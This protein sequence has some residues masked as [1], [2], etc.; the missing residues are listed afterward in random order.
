MMG[1]RKIVRIENKGHSTHLLTMSFIMRSAISMQ[2]ASS[3]SLKLMPLI[4]VQF[5]PSKVF[6]S[7]KKS[8]DLAS[9]ISLFDSSSLVKSGLF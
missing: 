7:W 2:V 5:A 9:S 3:F 8:L 1:K 6:N 4:N